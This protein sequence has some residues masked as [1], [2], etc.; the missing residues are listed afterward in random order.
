MFTGLIREFGRVRALRG[1]RL[2]IEALYRPAIGDSVAV[3]GAC[4]TVVEL[5][6]GGF[7]LELSHES[8]KVLALENYKGEVHIEPAMRLS[9]RL[10]GHLVQ[11]H[12]DALGVVREIRSNGIGTDYII[13]ASRET[14]ALI[15]PKGSIAI[16]GVSL[17]VNDVDKESFRLTIIPHTLAQTLLPSYVKGRRVQIE[18]DILVRT[19]AHLLKGEREAG[20]SWPVV[21]RMMALY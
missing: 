14:L 1:E 5:L 9:D 21:D 15:V 16:D 19:V 13:E 8:Q 12:I 3:N 10:D 6:D 2:E 7:T 20:V 18:T 17:T 11:G 4:L